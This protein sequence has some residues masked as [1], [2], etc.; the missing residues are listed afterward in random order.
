MEVIPFGWPVIARKLEELGATPELRRAP[1]GSPFRTDG[2][3]YILDCA[4]GPISDAELLASRLDSLVGVVEHGLFLGI[5][6][7]VHA[8]GASGV[9]VLRR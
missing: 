8:G 5:A 7:E 2:G 6:S 4:F 9:T 1:D 3:H